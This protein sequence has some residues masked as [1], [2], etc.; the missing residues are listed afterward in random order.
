MRAWQKLLVCTRVSARETVRSFHHCSPSHR[1][2][3]SSQYWHPES[4]WTVSSSS[5]CPMETHLWGSSVPE[6]LHWKQHLSYTN[7]ANRGAG[8]VAV[9]V[10]SDIE[11]P[12]QC[13]WWWVCGF[14]SWSSGD[15]FQSYTDLQIIPEKP[16]KPVRLIRGHGLSPHHSVTVTLMRMFYP[17]VTTCLGARLYHDWAFTNI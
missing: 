7:M 5:L 17:G 15:W 2:T 16:G 8:G 13:N 9:C 3:G 14:K 10:K 1:G 4:P 12:P 6:S 11:V